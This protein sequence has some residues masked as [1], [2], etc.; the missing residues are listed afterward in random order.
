MIDGTVQ[1]VDV[2]SGLVLWSWNSA[3]HV[4]YSQ[5][6]QPLPASPST[7][8]DWFHLNAVKH[9]PGHTVIIDARDTWTAYD[10][11]LRSGRIRWQLGGKASSFTERAAPGQSLNQ[12]GAIFAWQ[13]DPEAVGHDEYTFF[14]NE[15]AGAG[16]TG[17]DPSAELDHSRVVTVRLDPRARTAT[18][19]A[20]DDQPRGGLASSQGN[21]QRLPDGGAFVGWGILPE[22]SQFD[23]AGRLVF[24]AAF[25]AGVNNYRAYLQPWPGR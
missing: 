4:P 24:D 21:G 14:D 11:S 22:I 15:S 17:T 5:S 6:E 19:V 1:E 20:S 3:D 23:A 2:H 25:P 18:L 12:A 7:P 13:H 16:N 9:G 10:V 8:W